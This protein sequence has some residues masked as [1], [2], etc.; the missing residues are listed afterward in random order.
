MAAA[1]SLYDLLAPLSIPKLSIKWP[2]D[3]F[4]GEKKLAGILIDSRV[5]D[6]RLRYTLVGIGLNVHQQ[7]MGLRASSLRMLLP[8]ISPPL[9]KEKLLSDWGQFFA[10]RYAQLNH[11]NGR[12]KLHKDYEQSLFGRGESRMYA[13]KIE[14]K[15][16]ASIVGITPFGEL[17]LQTASG[18][19]HFASG[20]L[21]YVWIKG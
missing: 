5:Q 17:I 8:D 2:N 21:E 10:L 12:Q 4:A 13:T 11:R 7:E 20:A 14:G 9:N 18:I 15:F 19:K 6:Q 16:A 3:I 1:C